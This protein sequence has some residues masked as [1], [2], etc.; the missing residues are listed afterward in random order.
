VRLGRAG[1]V[2]GHAGRRGA[3]LT[4]SRPSLALPSTTVT[5]AR[6]LVRGRCSPRCRSSSLG[7]LSHA[8]RREPRR[9]PASRRRPDCPLPVLLDLY[10]GRAAERVWRT[11]APTSPAVA[12]RPRGSR[13][14]RR[15]A[16]D[17]RP[18]PAWDW[19]AYQDRGRSTTDRACTGRVAL[20]SWTS[21]NAL[22]GSSGGYLAVAAVLR[23]PA[24]PRRDANAAVWTS[25]QHPLERALPRRP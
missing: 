7:H 18:G 8:R 20:R 10:G 25:A 21:R 23:R 16:R 19:L 1:R 9:A 24:F 6:R 2:H 22:R 3:R 5:W 17:G 11:A 12:R 15:R 13:A 4:S 14:R